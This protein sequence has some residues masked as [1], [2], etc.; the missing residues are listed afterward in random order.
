MSERLPSVRVT[1]DYGDIGLDI[2]TSHYTYTL[3]GMVNVPIFQGGRVRGRLLESDADLRNRQSELEDLKA[4]IYY[5]VRTAFLDL[6]ATGEQLQVATRARELAAQQLTQSRDRFA[7]G[8]ASNIEVVEAQQAVASANEQY[9]NGLYGFNV[10][11]AALARALG[12][13]EEAVRQY[14]G[15]AR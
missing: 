2:A 7:A 13:A 5:D 3:G 9:I 11:K 14:L 8:V 10:S 4:G 12:V 1:A 15:G 6:R